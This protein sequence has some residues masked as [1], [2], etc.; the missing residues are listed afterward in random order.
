[1]KVKEL[2][3]LLKTKDPELEVLITYDG[4]LLNVNK[5]NISLRKISLFEKK[6][7]YLDVD[8]ALV[9]DAE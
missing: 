5:D 3:E 7:Y 9:I 1:M 2:I 6:G 8:E 4:M